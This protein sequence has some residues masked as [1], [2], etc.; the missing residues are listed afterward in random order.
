MKTRGLEWSKPYKKNRTGESTHP[1][2]DEFRAIITESLSPESVLGP[3]QGVGC[4]SPVRSLFAFLPVP[5][6]TTIALVGAVGRSIGVHRSTLLGVRYRRR[7]APYTPENLVD[8]I[9]KSSRK[10]KTIM[11]EAQ[12]CAWVRSLMIQGVSWDVPGGR[13]ETHSHAISNQVDDIGA[14]QRLK[15]CLSHNCDTSTRE[16]SSDILSNPLIK[17]R[18]FITKLAVYHLT[19]TGEIKRSTEAEERSR[20]DRTRKANPLEGPS[21]RGGARLGSV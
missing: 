20:R 1:T 18:M 17:E 3:S 12:Y 4:F 6:D 10:I 11:R 7:T 13:I 15:L 14:Y 9:K 2:H 19:N 8:E 5:I 21:P 16:I